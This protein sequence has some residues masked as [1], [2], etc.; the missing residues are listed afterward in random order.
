MSGG[1]TTPAPHEKIFF[2]EAVASTHQTS[3]AIELAHKTT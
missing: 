3:E 1:S 2:L